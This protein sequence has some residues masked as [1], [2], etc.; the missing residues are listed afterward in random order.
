M[1]VWLIYQL[2]LRSFSFPLDKYLTG[3]S[4]LYNRVPLRYTHRG[5]SEQ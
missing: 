5:K 1:Y 2:T 4:W 3:N